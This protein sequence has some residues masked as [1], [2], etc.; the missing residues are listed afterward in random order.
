MVSG[1]STSLFLSMFTNQNGIFY[2][3]QSKKKKEEKHSKG[4]NYEAIQL[5]TQ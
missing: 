5:D 4:V 3:K 1:I 2:L